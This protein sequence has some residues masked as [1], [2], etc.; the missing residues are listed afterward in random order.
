MTPIKYEEIK[1]T[2]RAAQVNI[3]ETHIAIERIF[4][5]INLAYQNSCDYN[6][7]Y[8]ELLEKAESLYYSSNDT[9]V[10]AQALNHYIEENK[11]LIITGK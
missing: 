3:S 7:T 10:R 1:T 2:I 4:K 8:D 6:Y 5:S 9:L 11:Q